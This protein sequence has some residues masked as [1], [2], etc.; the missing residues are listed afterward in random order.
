VMIDEDE[1]IMWSLERDKVIQVGR[2]SGIEKFEG[3]GEN[4]IF[5][6]FIYFKP[7]KKFMNKCGVSE[8]WR[9]D[10]STSKGVQDLL[11]TIYLTPWKIVVQRVTVVYSLK[12]TMEAA[13]AM[14]LA[15]WESR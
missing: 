9:F 15:V 14:I 6:T 13:S 10:N 3:E 7:V 11:E 2:L 4:F 8:F 5:N 12:C 1:S